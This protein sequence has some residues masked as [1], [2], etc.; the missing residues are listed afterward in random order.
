MIG[1]SG[2]VGAILFSDIASQIWGWVCESYIHLFV[3]FSA[4]VETLH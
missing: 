1:V 2:V 3:F 4:A